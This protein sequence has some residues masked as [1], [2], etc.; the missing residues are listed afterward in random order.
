MKSTP[1]N[2]RKA[3]WV[4]RYFLDR[5]HGTDGGGNHRST[6]LCATTTWDD[7]LDFAVAFGEAFPGRAKDDNHTLASARLTAMLREL[8]KDGWLERWRVG[9]EADG[10]WGTPKWQFNY[11]LPQWLINDL[12]T[13]VHTPESAAE[14]WGGPLQ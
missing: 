14:K 7:S 3:A 1:K 4:F 6:S 11:K 12:K 13:G 8:E 5:S 10:S 2:S 9:N